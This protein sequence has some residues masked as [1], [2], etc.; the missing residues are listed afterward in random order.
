MSRE[1]QP[2]ARI[3]ARLLGLAC[4][5]EIQKDTPGGTRTQPP[6]PAARLGRQESVS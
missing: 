1:R 2:G 6:V 5:P 3:R 4:R